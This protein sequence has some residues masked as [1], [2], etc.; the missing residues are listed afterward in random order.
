MGFSSGPEG[1]KNSA[2]EIDVYFDGSRVLDDLQP[3]T[4]SGLVEFEARRTNQ[5][6]EVVDG[7]ESTNENPI[8]TFLV[9]FL[10][11]ASGDSLRSASLTL[12]FVPSGDT[13]AVAVLPNSRDSSAV[14]GMVDLGVIHAAD[15]SLTLKASVNST[16]G[17]NPLVATLSDSLVPFG[18]STYVTLAPDVYVVR[19]T[20]DSGNEES[21][22]VDLTGLADKALVG[23][24]TLGFA[25]GKDD[26]A[27]GLV[28]SLFDGQGNPVD[29]PITTAAALVEELPVNFRLLSAYPNPFNPSTTIRYELG[30][31]TNVRI[32]VFDA[33]GRR[34]NTLVNADLPAGRY[35]ATWNARTD[36]GR[37]TPSGTYIVRMS[38]GAFTESRTVVLVR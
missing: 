5:L 36:A 26:G 34:V 21:F 29:A 17:G 18:S 2:G 25:S 7:I 38:A 12:A 31:P 30:Q 32:D 3:G 23:V 27:I 9:D 28:M 15:T 16:S 13:L 8:A 10:A 22:L 1:R 37:E 4:A 20:D 14:A 19:F 24:V 11:T 35:D 6:V 33:L